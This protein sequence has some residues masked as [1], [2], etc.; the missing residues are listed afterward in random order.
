MQTNEYPLWSPHG[1]A[2]LYKRFTGDIPTG[3][4]DNET[5]IVQQNRYVF[6][7]TFKWVEETS[8]DSYDEQPVSGLLVANSYVTIK[9]NSLQKF[10]VG[11]IVELPK[12]TSLAG[13]WVITDGATT[14]FAYTPK[15]VQ[16][17]QH[18]PLSSVG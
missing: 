6:V 1:R 13:L 9:T 17:Y 11:D 2:R 5:I 10:A 3:L 16:T 18:L 12:A 7:G 14:D 4:K 8:Q 15:Q